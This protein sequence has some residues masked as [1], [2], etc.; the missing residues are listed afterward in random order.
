MAVLIQARAFYVSW[1]AVGMVVLTVLISCEG[2]WLLILHVI[3]DR[4]VRF[5]YNQ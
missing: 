1:G 3:T 4:T 2:H 5:L